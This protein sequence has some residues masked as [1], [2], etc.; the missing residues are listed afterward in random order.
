MYCVSD[1]F[2]LLYVR[3]M[4]RLS[5]PSRC[6]PKRE[7]CSRLFTSVR[8]GRRWRNEPVAPR[9]PTQAPSWTNSPLP[10]TQTQPLTN[11]MDLRSSM[12]E[13]RCTN[14]RKMSRIVRQL[15]SAESIMDIRTDGPPGP[16]P[17]VT[18]SN[19]CPLIYTNTYYRISTYHPVHVAF[20]QPPCS[21]WT[22][23]RCGFC[24][25]DRIRVWRHRTICNSAFSWFF[26]RRNLS[27]QVVLGLLI[28]FN[29]TWKI[30]K[31]P[32]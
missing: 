29:V 10:P 4:Q 8:R 20:F 18:P 32:R 24:F 6:P 27:S 9:A 22:A 5:T 12:P 3:D 25:L 19:G 15:H 16:P 1:V 21:I 13:I 30:F 28:R 23:N 17:L 2:V 26:C 7:P 11:T 31:I 14:T